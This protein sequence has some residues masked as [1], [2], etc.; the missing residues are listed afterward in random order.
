M[1]GG[2]EASGLRVDRENDDVVGVLIRYQQ[3]PSTRI[4]CEVTRPFT[5]RR[6]VFDGRRLT[7]APVDF[8]NNDTVV[9]SV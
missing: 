8:K 1:A 2:F 6:N 5:F 7:C 4:D 3:E 9:T